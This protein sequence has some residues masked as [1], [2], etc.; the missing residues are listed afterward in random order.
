MA[1]AFDGTVIWVTA[2][3]DET[4]LMIDRNSNQVTQT[5]PL[6]KRPWD[7]IYDGKYLW[8]TASGTDSSPASEI[9]KVDPYINSIVNR[10]T[11][12]ASPLA[13]TFDGEHVW[14]SN[15]QGDII[16]INTNDNSDEGY[17]SVDSTFPIFVYALIFDGMSLWGSTDDNT[18]MKLRRF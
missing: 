17:Q 1:L 2:F 10:R 5:I 11:T 12:P 15:M 3:L 7:L 16:K 8:T 14:V 6:A 4:L 18:V 13:L 9:I